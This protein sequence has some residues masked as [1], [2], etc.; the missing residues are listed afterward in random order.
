MQSLHAIDLIIIILVLGATLFLGLRFANK[1]STTE[2]FFLSK[3]NFPGW[4]LGMSLLSTLISSVTFLGY[5][6]QGFTS[7]WLLLVQGL[8]V[9]IVLVFAIG[10]IVPL[11]RRTIG[12]STYEY[13]EKRFGP[14]ARYYS[15]S[16]FVLRQFAGMG[17]VLF[18]IA[19]AINRMTGLSPEIILLVVGTILIV[20]NWVGGMQAVVWLD[21][22]QGFM[23]FISGIMCVGILLYSI[24]GGLPEALR[25]AASHGRSGF[26]PYTF[27]FS[28]LTFWVMVIN[29]AF[30][31]I[32]KYATDQTVVQ[33][34]LSAKDDKSAI[35][36]SMMGILLT[37]PVWI[38]FMFIGTLLFVF[39]QQHPIANPLQAEAVFPH[40]IITELPIGLVGF[41][42]AALISAA[43]CSLSADLNAMAAVGIEDYYKKIRKGKTDREYL[44]ASRSFIL[45]SGLLAMGV[46]GIYLR[47]GN[48]GVLG[49]I[50]TV[51]AIFSGGIVGIFLLGLFSKRTHAR[52]IN[53]GIMAC[54]LFTS[55]AL[56][57]S[58]PVGLPGKEKLLLDLGA[59][60]FTHNKLM[61][62]VYSHL[63][64]MVVG[65][66]SSIFFPTASPEA[67]LQSNPRSAGEQEQ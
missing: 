14:F 2:Q 57:T 18:L 20:V 40:F 26:G 55:Y 45:V 41:V 15:S 43:I 34:Y 37:V 56:L 24:K 63:V 30:Y 53:T 64:L 60:N 61:L 12:L 29:G 22:F 17:T 31:A 13:F 39:Y 46:A 27:S 23:L 28:E 59:F 67:M 25:I 52:G 38:M 42:V 9:P 47:A 54:I 50:F 5:P 62:G 36:A 16:S 4:A 33:R 19:V 8:M 1:Q 21:V 11:Y 48:E 7:N 65:Y 66:L 35:Q 10:Y 44:R 32:Q 58:T 6:A 51:Y 3:G 49:V